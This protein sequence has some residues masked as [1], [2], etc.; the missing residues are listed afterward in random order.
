MTTGEALDAVFSTYAAAN[1]K[2]RWGDKT[3]MYCVTSA[4]SSACSRMPST[5][6]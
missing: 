2:P 6:T 1:G 4:S 5:C 3:P